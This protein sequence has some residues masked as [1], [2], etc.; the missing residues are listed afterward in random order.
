MPRAVIILDM[1]RRSHENLRAEAI[2]LINLAR[3]LVDD[4]NSVAAVHLELAI[5]ALSEHEK[6]DPAE[7]AIPDR[8]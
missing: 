3:G 2:R 6:L 1:E 5:D 7:I 8:V 4:R